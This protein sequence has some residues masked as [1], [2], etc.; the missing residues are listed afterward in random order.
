MTLLILMDPVT[1]EGEPMAVT[2]ADLRDQLREGLNDTDDATPLQTDGFLNLCLNRA[3]TLHTTELP[4]SA[5]QEFEA[6]GTTYDMPDY[7]V[8]I[9]RVRGPFNSS[10]DLQFVGQATRHEFSGVWVA[11]SEPICYV[12]HFP[13][14]DKFYLPRAPTGAFTL[15]YGVRLPEL[16]QEADELDVGHRLWSL[17][18]IITLAGYCSFDPKSVSRAGLEQWAGQVDLPVDNPLEQEAARWLAEYE[19]LMRTYAQPLKF[20]E[21]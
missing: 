5:Y 18:A 3:I 8:T 2:L 12:P 17:Y 9:H 13:E 6:A 15:Y 11:S 4:F 14:R 7:L 16:A 21:E 19:R 1:G 20:A 10:G